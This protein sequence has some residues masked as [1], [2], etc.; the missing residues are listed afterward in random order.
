MSTSS[1]ALEVAAVHGR[2]VG[3]PHSPVLHVYVGPTTP[4][5]QFVPRSC[6]T[7]CRTRTRRLK[8]LP[9][10]GSRL[11]LAGR[12]VCG[13]CSACLLSPGRQAGQP[14][15][16]DQW[17]AAYRHVT[18]ADLATATALAT[19]SDET[20][21]VG[22][23]A[24]LVHGPSPVRRPRDLTKLQARFDLEQEILRRRRHLRTAERTPE[25]IAA[26]AMRREAEDHNNALIAKARRKEDRHARALDRMNRGQY[27]APWERPA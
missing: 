2:L 20:H 1:L 26:D 19:T 13:R 10:T 24:G 11:D 23:I 22:F 9:R 6:R 27:L 25:E 3:R 5:G 16:R 4:S 21:R 18:L 12:R 14:I 8:V 15:S 7:V 17:L